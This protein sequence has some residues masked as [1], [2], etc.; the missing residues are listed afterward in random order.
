MNEAI[1]LNGN[2]VPLEH[3]TLDQLVAAHVQEMR[4]VAV[5]V[6]GAVITRGEWSKT[7][8]HAGDEVEIVKV[9][10]GG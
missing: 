10:V 6:N 8:V 3:T 5:A 4:G 2:P 7:C 9:M 1:T